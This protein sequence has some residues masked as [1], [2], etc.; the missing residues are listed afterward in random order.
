M[1]TGMFARRKRKKPMPKSHKPPPPEGVK[2][3][4]SKRHRDRLNQELNK[5]TGMLPFPEDVRIQLDKLS[6]L[7]LAVGYLKVKSYLM[8][9]AT[10]IGDRMLDQ[11][12]APGGTGW[13][14]LQVNRE[15]FPEGELLL[16]A[17]NGFVIAVTGDGYIFYI[18]PTVKDYLGFHQSDLIYQSVYELIHADDRAT[19]CQELHGAPEPSST[20]HTAHGLPTNQL[21]PAVC[22]TMSSPKK[23]FFVERS[24]TCRFRCLLDKSSGFLALHFRGRL[25]FLLGQQ[26]AL[27]R[28]PLALFAIA[29]PLQPL[30]ILELQI[31]TLRFQAKFKLDFTPT[32]NDFWGQAVLGYT[33]AELCSRGS[34]YQFLHV[35]DLMYCAESH[36]R[37]MKTGE[38]GVMSFRLLTKKGNWVWVQSNAW[39]VY[40]GGKPDCIIAQNRVL[41]NEEGEEHLRKR[42]LLLPFVFATGDAVLYG[43]DL[44]PFQDKGELQT[45][46]NSHLKQ[47]L[48][49]PNFL[50][51]AMMKQDASISISHSDNMSQFSLPDLTTESD[52]PSQSEEVGDAKDSDSLL[53]IETLFEKS[54]VDGNICQTTQSLNVDNAELQWWEEV[55]LILGAEEELAAQ[56]VGERL[57]TEV[58]SCVEQMLLG[59]DAGKSMDFSHC[60]ASPC[61]EENSA[62]APFQHC[63]ATNSA[64]REQPQ[65]QAP[66]AQD[67]DAGVSLVSVISEVSYAQPE[68]QV[69]FNPAGLVQG[70][71]R[72]VL[73]SSSKPSIAL[74]LADLEQAPQTELATSAAVDN[75]I[76]DDESQ[77][78]CELMGSSCPPPLHS[79]ALV[80][81]WH[82]VPAQVN[83]AS[84][85]GQCT[86]PGSCPSEAWV[87]TA[88]KQL[89]A[90]GTH[91][92]SQYLLAGSSESP[93]GA[94]LWSL[95]SQPAPCP[96]QGLHESLFSAVGD[97]CDEDAALPAPASAHLGVSQL[98]GDGGFPKELPILPLEP[99]F[100][101]KG[102]QG[103]WFLQAGAGPQGCGEAGLVQHG[104]LLLGSSMDPSTQQVDLVSLPECQYG[105]NLFGDEC[106]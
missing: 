57:G 35:G 59:E 4:P 46:A 76:P 34:G 105:N 20:Q 100:S 12:R 6:V 56:V 61:H 16:Q 8:A 86:S 37:M 28:S 70:T 22:S 80:T 15:L 66:G 88:P 84:A 69:L 99:S 54:K 104:G 65:P 47:S 64:L 78:R 68:L 101:W 13:M 67:Q 52:G 49:D 63:W 73:G 19:F 77:P 82:D 21:L 95:P 97:L 24:F 25:K 11:P 51:G 94:G 38:T 32:A 23:C 1:F 29:T 75:V 45:Q 33:E 27:D 2:S 3:N 36:V 93:S 55:L 60:C 18:S 74:Q 10:N 42:N 43:N 9:T 53:D 41:S 62:V 87:S 48:V 90:A 91:L 106:L 79:N 39:L 17:L 40:K 96:A 5:L 81:R 44:D 102:E 92:K 103:E 71:V 31:K 58:T 85:L 98:P 26:K 7:R 89:E 50:L 83:P 14:D 72:D 30:S